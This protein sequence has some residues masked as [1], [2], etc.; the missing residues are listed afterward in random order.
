MDR[1]ENYVNTFVNNLYTEEFQNK[2]S[3][4]HY[5]LLFHLFVDR[6]EEVYEYLKNNSNLNRAINSDHYKD[7]KYGFDWNKFARHFKQT[8]HLFYALSQYLSMIKLNG[9]KEL[10]NNIITNKDYEW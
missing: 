5:S 7:T 3:M 2:I 10:E 6:R 4:S 8:D 1:L 9:K